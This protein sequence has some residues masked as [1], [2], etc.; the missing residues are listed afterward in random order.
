MARFAD[1]DAFEHRGGVA[2]R[3]IQTINAVERGCPQ[4][5][6]PRHKSRAAPD[7]HYADG[8]LGRDQR[9]PEHRAPG[10]VRGIVEGSRVAVVVRW[11]KARLDLHALAVRETGTVLRGVDESSRALLEL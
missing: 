4:R 5:I 7:R 10:E 11:A 9:G 3:G 2:I 6:D 1:Q 8:S